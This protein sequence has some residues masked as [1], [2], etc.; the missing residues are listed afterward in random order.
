MLCITKLSPPMLQ[1]NFL[2]S[3][4]QIQVAKY[5]P[6]EVIQLAFMSALLERRP[7]DSE[8]YEASERFKAITNF[9]QEAVKVVPIESVFHAI[10]C[11]EDSNDALECANAVVSSKIAVP[12]SIYSRGAANLAAIRIG[13][14]WRAHEF[15]ALVHQASR[16]NQPF[17]LESVSFEQRSSK[18][19]VCCSVCPESVF[20]SYSAATQNNLHRPLMI[21]VNTPRGPAFVPVTNVMFEFGVNPFIPSASPEIAKQ[22]QKLVQTR[23]S[24]SDTQYCK[25]S[26]EQIYPVDSHRRH[27][28]TM[29]TL[30]SPR[31][32]LQKAR[33]ALKDFLKDSQEESD[34]S[35]CLVNEKMLELIRETYNHKLK[36]C[37]AL[38]ASFMESQIQIPLLKDSSLS[39][40]N[41]LSANS[42]PHAVGVWALFT[43]TFQ[44]LQSMLA[45]T[46][47]N[48]LLVK[49]SDYIYGVL[50]EGVKKPSSRNSKYDGKLQFLLQGSV[51][52]TVTSSMEYVSYSLEHQLCKHLK[53]DKN[54]SVARLVD[55]WDKIFKG[56]ALSLIAKSHRYITARWLKWAILIHD[57]RSTLAKYTCV[58]VTGLVNSGKSQLVRKLFGV[59]VSC[60]VKQASLF[61]TNNYSFNFHD[62]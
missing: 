29:S 15:F 5:T 16:F 13:A 2:F 8:K 3:V 20:A 14:E 59:Q 23:T 34:A 56:D 58:G 36:L 43:K 35:Q 61:T 6:A 25:L 50:G 19:V 21:A 22:L 38:L 40:A 28:M 7:S 1:E 53:F 32:V 44:D 48:P 9:L 42:S 37:A 10:A 51:N 39:T 55:N 49:I 26:I 33:E 4:R 57:L 17:I 62:A 46:R 18:Q 54:I 60:A 45:S 30:E 52:K 31:E 11:L 41:F 24:A 12:N 47:G 27:T